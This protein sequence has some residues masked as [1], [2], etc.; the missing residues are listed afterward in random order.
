MSQ[1]YNQ[2]RSLIRLVNARWSAGDPAYRCILRTSV[3]IKPTP[4][5]SRGKAMGMERGIVG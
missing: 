5:A 4:L 3:R 1:P 2:T